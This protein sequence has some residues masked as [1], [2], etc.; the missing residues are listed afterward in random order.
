[1]EYRVLV[2]YLHV[3]VHGEFTDEYKM[4]HLRE[5]LQIF[6]PT[7]NPHIWTATT[8]NHYQASGMHRD[9]YFS[10]TPV[11][12]STHLDCYYPESLPSFWNTPRSRLFPHPRLKIRAPTKTDMNSPLLRHLTLKISINRGHRRKIG[13]AKLWRRESLHCARTLHEISRRS[14]KTGLVLACCGSSYVL[15]NVS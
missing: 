2:R 8:E 13:T 5:S 9:H 10:Y 7:Q 4:D 14:R 6:Y 15:I 1:M 11:P 3:T 12:E